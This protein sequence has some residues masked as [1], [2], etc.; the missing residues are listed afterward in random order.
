MPAGILKLPRTDFGTLHLVTS[1]VLYATG[2]FRGHFFILLTKPTDQGISVTDIVST[3]KRS[4]MMSGIRGKDTQPEIRVRKALHSAGYRF[5]LH[6][7]DLPG[8]PDIVL[9]ARRIAVFV[10]GCFWHGHEGCR[11]AK[12]PATRS[13]FW[14]EKF[15]AN[16]KRDSAAQ[17]ALVSLGWRVLVVW[18]CMIRSIRSQDELKAV[19]ASWIESNE[20]LGELPASDKE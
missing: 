1:G 13:G 17:V 9:P 12:I 16:R 5:R 3:E 19:L 20:S 18:E 14:Q 2:A 4:Q 6:R 10:H 15:D 7:G 11:L 8:R